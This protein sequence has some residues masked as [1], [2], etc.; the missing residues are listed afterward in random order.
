MNKYQLNEH[1]KLVLIL[2]II[3]V[4]FY[5]FFTY[6]VL[7]FSFGILVKEYFTPQ[8]LPAYFKYLT[9]LALGYILFHYR[10]LFDPEAAVSFLA[11]LSVLKLIEVK[12]SRDYFTLILILFVLAPSQVLFSQTISATLYM[13]FCLLLTMTIW[14]RVIHPQSNENK[15]FFSSSK[16]ITKGLFIAVPITLVLFLFFPRFNTKFLPLRNSQKNHIGFSPDVNNTAGNLEL[17]QEV[18]FHFMMKKPPHISQLYW[19]GS[20]LQHTDGYNWKHSLG[21]TSY[22]R[23]RSVTDQKSNYVVSL[24]NRRHGYLFLL[25]TPNKVED[26]NTSYV[27]TRSDT[28]IVKY[29]SNKAIRYEASFYKKSEVQREIGELKIY[30]RY[31]NTGNTSPELLKSISGKFNSTEEMISN[32]RKYFLENRFSYTL[33]PGVMQT[34]NEFLQN[35]KGFCTHYASTLALIARAN[36]IPARLVSGYHGGKFNEY[37]KFYTVKENDAH[38]WVEIWDKKRG[39][40]RVDPTTW[41]SPSRFSEGGDFFFNRT[42]NSGLFNFGKD[43]ILNK[44]NISK[45]YYKAKMFFENLDFKWLSFIESFDKDYQRRLAFKLKIPKLQLYFLALWLPLIILGLYFLFVFISLKLKSN[46]HDRIRQVYLDFV[47]LSNRNMVKIEAYEA[48]LTAAKKWQKHERISNFLKDY[49]NYR[50]NPHKT[51]KAYELLKDWKRVKTKLHL[52]YLK[53]L[54]KKIN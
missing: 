19:R 27:R 31:F 4:P 41:I 22:I 30:E 1:R 26:I 24:S 16:L 37:G 34:L 35:K 49:S 6:P 39:W 53:S 32:V 52:L 10:T 8:R 14:N 18:A 13:F 44:L 23:D 42:E 50:Y 33:R 21:S 40:F 20:V 5:E 47:D 38:T 45:Y 12:T 11:A 46:R 2:G 28:F 29:K 3:L 36:S 7:L 9:F 51:I 54:F 43:G 17:S 48:P 25:D 15:T